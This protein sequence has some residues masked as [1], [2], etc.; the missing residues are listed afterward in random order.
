MNKKL[1]NILVNKWRLI[2]LFCI[3]SLL[4]V[5]GSYFF[6]RNEEIKIRDEEYKD[7]NAIGELKINEI[8]QWVKE[9]SSEAQY[10]SGNSIFIKNTEQLLSDKNNVLVKD[11]F[12]SNLFIIK[13]NHNYE[14]IFIVTRKGNIIFSLDTT[15][16]QVDSLTFKFIKDVTFSKKVVFS[17]FY[18]SNAQNKILYDIISP[19]I[20]Q[21]NEVIGVFIL[22]VDPYEYLFPLIQKWPTPSRTSETLI[23]RK[24]GDN[25]VY[26]NELRHINNS[27]LFLKIPL[28]R[29]DVVAV[30]VVSSG[31][32]GIIEGNDYRGEEVLADVHKVP[33]TQWYMVAKVDISE[34]F[35]ELKFRASIISA[36]TFVL[37]LLLW[38]GLVWVY[39]YRQRNIYRKLFNKEK[40]LFESQEEFRIT[41]YSIGDAVITT[42]K[43][44]RIKFM[45]N[46]AEKLTGWKE[47][48]AKEE[49]L[50]NVFRI[51]SEENPGKNEN[52]IELML[53][54]R[55]AKEISYHTLLLSKDNKEIPISDSCSPM[56]NEFGEI[57][58]FVLVFKEQ[59]A[60][61]E[62][63][64][65]IRASEEK[66]RLLADNSDDVIWTMDKDLHFT[67]ISPSVRKLRGYSPEEAM[68]E[69]MSDILTPESLKYVTEEFEN[70]KKSFKEGNILVSRIM[71]EQYR[72]DGSTVWVEIVTRNINDEKGKLC[73][74]IGVSRDITDR[75]KSELALRESEERYKSLFDNSSIGIYRTTT[76]GHLLMANSTFI[77]I[78]G[79]DSFDELAKYNLTQKGFGPEYIRREFRERLER[80]GEIKGFEAVWHKR[81]GT[82]LY[83]NENAK[84]YK[85]ENGNVIYYEGTIEDYTDRKLAYES[86]KESELRYSK[87]FENMLEGYTYC[88]MH[89]ENNKPK[90]FTHLAV[91]DSF[92]KITGL[93]DVIGKKVSE[94]IPG[95]KETNPELFEV[96]GKVAITGKPEFLETFFEG[97]GIWL[98]ISVYGPSE[99][100][101][102][103]V[104]NDV[105][106]RKMTELAL[107]KSEEMLSETGKIAKIGGW[108]FDVKSLKGTWTKEVALIY[109][110]DPNIKTNVEFALS[111][112]KGE[113]L[114]KLKKA[115][116]DTIEL[117][118]SFDLVLELITAKKNHKWVRA[119]GK[120]NVENGKTNKIHG[121]FQDITVQKQSEDREK[122]GRQ[123]LEHLNS[124]ENLDSMIGNV[125]KLIKDS[126]GYTAIGIRLKEGD[127]YPYYLTSGFSEEFIHTEKYLCN[128]DINGKAI[129]D[130]NG[131]PLLDCMCGN[132]LRERYDYAKSFFTKGGSFRSNNITKLLETNASEERCYRIRNRCN[133]SGYMSVAL[134]PI[135]SG[136][137][138][139]GLLQMNDYRDNMFDEEIIPFFESLASSIGITITRIKIEKQI[140]KLNRIYNVLSNINET[141]VRTKKTSQLFDEACRI[142]VENGKFPL[143]WI[144]LINNEKNILEVSAVSGNISE[145]EK[146]VFLDL[147]KSFSEKI[148]SI[149]VL[150]SGMHFV[151]NDNS[152]DNIVPFFKNVFLKNRYR[153]LAAFPLKVFDKVIG[154]FSLYAKEKDYFDKD[155]INLL[156]EMTKDISFALEFVQKESE[157]KG[158]E[159]S[160]RENE[161]KFRQIADQMIDVLF[162]TDTQGIITYIS[163][164]SLNVFG[165]RPDYMV[166]RNF[167]DF[168]SKSDIPKAMPFYSNAIER[169]IGTHDL[170]LN[171]KKIDGSVFF[172]ELNASVLLKENIIIG[173]VGLIKD[174][175]VR[176]QS[177]EKIR[178]LSRSVEQSPAIVVI[179]DIAGEIEYVNPK[180]TEVTGYLIEEVIGRNPRILQSGETNKEEYKVL[181]DT[182]V[183][184]EEWKGEFHNKKKNGEL[185]WESANISPIT[186]ESG[187]I[188]HFL[189][190]K[191]DITERKKMIEELISAK[192]KAE[193]SNRLK[194]NFLAN[195]SHELRTPLS[196]ILGF[197]D[198]LKDE[199]ENEEQK[200][201]A[202][203]I[204]KSGKRLLNTLTLILDLA[205]LEAE[206]ITINYTI[207]N[208]NDVCK[209]VAHLY[210][211]SAL[212]KG[213][214]I[215]TVFESEDLIAEIDERAFIE[216]LNNLVNNAIKYTNKG[217]VTLKTYL[218]PGKIKQAIIEVIDT[219]I[220]IPEDKYDII[221]DE[222][223]QASEGYSR[224]FEG[225]GLGLSITKKFVEKMNGTIFVKSKIGE[226]TVFTISFPLTNEITD[227]VPISFAKNEEENIINNFPKKGKK[228]KILIVEDE[229]TNLAFIKYSLRNYY[230]INFTTSGE[231]SVEM[232]SKNIY[233]AILMDINLSTGYDGVRAMTEIKKL[234]NYKDIPI[235]AVTAYARS[236]DRVEFLSSGFSGYLSKPF[237]KTILLN[238]LANAL[239]KKK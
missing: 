164:S 80:E 222:F 202:D 174:I 37:I 92:R 137:E 128:Y 153:S 87:L 15:L 72:K 24:E 23:F 10:F 151:L 166:G 168:L 138:I 156:D 175:S 11:Y 236:S 144:G 231:Q 17:D 57:I 29:N 199:L 40:D 9:R 217:G 140:K 111:F 180:F 176:K 167:S 221:F 54:E 43:E 208:I 172:G 170:S 48:D 7:L 234:K 143:A 191:E 67:Y 238:T 52:P 218:K 209:E 63:E 109:D 126:T 85:D 60:E 148:P 95:I 214:T 122:L 239:S 227:V 127:D 19:I 114:I 5:S 3:L 223:R 98:S 41:L 12:F 129:R 51:V 210:S 77:R 84:V 165:C 88:K 74:F 123:V 197:A 73:G 81:D 30:K 213:L 145:N 186:D 79:F 38:V 115:I 106:E 2:L 66:Y 159:E 211:A 134:I 226:G 99:G 224:N 133:A 155:E 68:Q 196:G 121:S 163:P 171:M 82:K 83:I 97:L 119:I 194:S 193:E 187:K 149:Q 102:V 162:V 56:R 33:G 32:E 14:N 216:I 96:C 235:I 103:A 28:S 100:Y 58:G 124:N 86:L 183:N 1:K 192:D 21:K 25:I 177:E 189:A 198:L 75:R 47:T 229:E 70:K 69:S 141:I 147:N 225:T 206:K 8:T 34:L 39:H 44:G 110:L 46:V 233:D 215:N 228:H 161:E 89:F 113:S 219:G 91:N 132:I 116:K 188:S 42:D 220:G 195:M 131:N 158:A 94:L 212:K 61:R 55:K 207:K 117:N 169:G 6:Y 26:L 107:Q 152:Q 139:I 173:T 71:V 190:V 62:A 20:N 178:K 184:G 179:T 53:R 237:S 204:L 205:K 22:R 118:E 112:Y 18:F 105:T 160:L 150:K 130:N 64:R 76:D 203:T 146:N 93:D 154:V 232:A 49:I 135:K 120:P 78:L 157:R 31:R 104:F 181:W 182:I 13:K 4:I 50:D 36:F 142:A 27:A 16:G 90:D 201:K 108:E 185:Y 136:N 125:V 65:K 230:E 35:S 45:N 101:F 200:N 59:T